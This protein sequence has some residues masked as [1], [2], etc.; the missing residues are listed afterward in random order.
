[1]LLFVFFI[2]RIYLMPEIDYSRITGKLDNVY[3]EI[4]VA[5]LKELHFHICIYFGRNMDMYCNIQKHNIPVVLATLVA[6]LGK[7]YERTSKSNLPNGQ[8]NRDTFK[9]ALKSLVSVA[10]IKSFKQSDAIQC[11]NN[12]QALLDNPVAKQDLIF[13]AISGQTAQG[14]SSNPGPRRKNSM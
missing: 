2:S 14:A 1:M 13:S 12:L 8:F 6:D 9:A 4:S 10:E 5:K 7:C 3:D 11:V